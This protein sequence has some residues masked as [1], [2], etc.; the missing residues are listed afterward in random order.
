MKRRLKE[1]YSKYLNNEVEKSRIDQCLQSYLGILSHSNQYELA[2]ALKN[3]YWVRN[4][5][6]VVRTNNN[7]FLCC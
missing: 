1:N 5:R 6:K 2:L 4:E 3:A 7:R